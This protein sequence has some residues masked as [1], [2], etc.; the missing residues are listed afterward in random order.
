MLKK[1]AL[2]RYRHI[3]TNLVLRKQTL[4]NLMT[5]KVY[6]QENCLLSGQAVLGLNMD[7]LALP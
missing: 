6:Q 2:L 1:L 4:P 7:F 5:T 3:S